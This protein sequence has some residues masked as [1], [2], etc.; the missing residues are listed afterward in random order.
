MTE[1]QIMEKVL[2]PPFRPSKQE[3]RLN[4]DL[5]KTGTNE[6]SASAS[7][8]ETLDI[9]HVPVQNDPRKWSPLRKVSCSIQAPILT[10]YMVF[11]SR[12]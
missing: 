2:D 3:I 5:E 1:T 6:A 8:S 11:L 10:T 7:T 9:E 4:H 12:M